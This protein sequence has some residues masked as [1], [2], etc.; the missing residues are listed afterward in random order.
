MN[1]KNPTSDTSIRTTDR[2]WHSEHAQKG[3]KG[4]GSPSFIETGERSPKGAFFFFFKKIIPLSPCHFCSFLWIGSRGGDREW[5]NRRTKSRMDEPKLKRL[6][7]SFFWKS[8]QQSSIYWQLYLA[9]G[10]TSWWTFWW[11]CVLCQICK[12]EQRNFSGAL[13]LRCSDEYSDRDS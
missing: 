8:C 7:R 1:K 2:K 9:S 11:V 10:P 13:L 4:F 12:N 5:K 6:R 3:A